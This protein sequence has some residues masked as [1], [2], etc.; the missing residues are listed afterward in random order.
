VASVVDKKSTGDT[1]F[2]FLILDAGMELNARPLLYA[3]QHPF[4]AVSR[5]GELLSSEFGKMDINGYKAVLVG[6]CCE[7]GDSQSLDA[8]GLSVPRLMAEPQIGDYVVIGG[9]GA[10]CSTMAPMNYNSFVQAPEVLYT[11]DSR[12]KLIRTRQT[13]DQ[14]VANEI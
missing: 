2:N 3:S 14:M 6:R 8:D 12:L 13:L 7:S 5:N 4:Y 1:G 9:A 10:Y 11:V